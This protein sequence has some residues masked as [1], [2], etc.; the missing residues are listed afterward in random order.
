MSTQLRHQPMTGDMFKYLK[1]ERLLYSVHLHVRYSSTSTVQTFSSL[2]YILHSIRPDY[3]STMHV[4]S[5]RQLKAC[6]SHMNPKQTESPLINPLSGWS[7]PP[8]RPLSI[9]N[10]HHPLGKLPLNVASELLVLMG[11]TPMPVNWE[12]VDETPQT[13]LLLMNFNC[14]IRRFMS[15][16]KH[17]IPWINAGS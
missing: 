2:P 4:H 3:V 1:P 16:I 15:Q 10:L 7:L 13:H 8:T 9:D 12:R 17:F 14:Q 6:S 11:K 5:F